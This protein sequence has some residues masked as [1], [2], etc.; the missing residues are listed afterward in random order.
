M[1]HDNQ[2]M[3]K[4]YHY[5]PDPK[6]SKIISIDFHGGNIDIEDSIFI[7][8]EDTKDTLI[9]FTGESEEVLDNLTIKNCKF[10]CKYLS[11]A[12]SIN[13]GNITI[14]SSSFSNAYNK[15]NGLIIQFINIIKLI[16]LLLYI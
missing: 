9:F 7:T 10:D 16:I 13:S 3:I 5:S 6:Y 1:N 2:I 11:R 4:N 15:D 12:L 14:Q 8:K